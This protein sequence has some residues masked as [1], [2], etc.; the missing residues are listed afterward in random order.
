[1]CYSR[2]LICSK[3]AA[4]WNCTKAAFCSKGSLLLEQKAVLEHG[5]LGHSLLQLSLLKINVSLTPD[6]NLSLISAQRDLSLNSA[7]R[8]ILCLRCTLTQC[9]WK[10]MLTFESCCC[11]PKP[12]FHLKSAVDVWNIKIVILKYC[13]AL[14]FAYLVQ[15]FALLFSS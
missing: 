8:G 3:F 13:F 15:F 5:S 2:T 4:V 14:L 7:K 12:S 1:M 11:F 6:N 10:R 9:L